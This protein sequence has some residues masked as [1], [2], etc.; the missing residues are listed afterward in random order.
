MDLI[1]YLLFKI[2]IKWSLFCK[3]QK[4]NEDLPTRLKLLRLNASLWRNADKETW[5]A[6]CPND[7]S[8]SDVR[9]RNSLDAS[10]TQELTV[11]PSPLGHPNWYQLNWTRNMASNNGSAGKWEVVK[12]GKK[13]NSGGAKTEKKSGGGGGRKAL[14]ESNQ[15]SR[16]KST[17]PAPRGLYLLDFS[18]QN[19]D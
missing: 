12:K 11:P 2:Y 5:H 6:D 8:L 3:T 10:R 1:Y 16:R 19:L 18:K 15:T 9:I 17:R 13:S 4:W 7:Q 14:G